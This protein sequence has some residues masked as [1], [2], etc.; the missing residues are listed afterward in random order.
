MV[1]VGGGG[2]WSKLG[3]AANGCGAK[4]T[5]RGACMELKDTVGSCCM[6]V[7]PAVC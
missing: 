5:L 6:D 4:A 7:E 2:K 3:V 1:K